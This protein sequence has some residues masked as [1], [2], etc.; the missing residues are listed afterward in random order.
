[1]Q[2]LFSQAKWTAIEATVSFL[3]VI[4]FQNFLL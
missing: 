3:V 4:F 1:M 2:N